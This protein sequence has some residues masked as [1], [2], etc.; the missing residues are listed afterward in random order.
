GGFVRR[1]VAESCQLNRFGWRGD[2]GHSEGGVA[3]ITGLAVPP[4]S[5]G[6]QVGTD[7]DPHPRWWIRRLVHGPRIAEE[8][9]SQRG[10]RDRCRPAAAHDLPA[11]PPGG[12]CRLHRTTPRGRSTAEG[13]PTLPRPHRSCDGDRAREQDR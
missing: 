1:V 8:A 11:L 6:S 2:A 9:A 13:P 5:H 10:L 3:N 12:G 7:A 4:W